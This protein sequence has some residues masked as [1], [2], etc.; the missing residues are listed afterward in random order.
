MKILIL[1]PRFPLPTYKGDKLRVWQ[2]IRKLATAHELKLI[3]YI[4]EPE[5]VHLDE[6]SQY[7]DVKTVPD[8]V[9]DRYFEL[10]RGIGN[11]VPFQVNYYNS[12]RMR[13]LVSS[14]LHDVDAIHL[15]TIRMAGNLPT[16]FHGRLVVDFIDALSLNFKRRCDNART[17]FKYVYRLEF[18]RLKRFERI[19]VERADLSLA[20]SPV[21]ADALGAKTAVLPTCVD[22][23]KFYPPDENSPRRNLI[24]TGNLSYI[25]NIEAVE[26]IALHAMPIIASKFPE[27]KL[28]LVGINPHPRVKS[29][30]SPN[31]EVVGYVNSVADELRKAMVAVAPMVSGAGLQNK[32]L[33]AMACAAPVVSTSIGNAGIR[34]ENNKE[35]LIGDTPVEF[36]EQVI[37][38]LKDEAMARAIGRAGRAFVENNF[39]WESTT[40]KLLSL[41]DEII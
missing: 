6:V 35:I 9:P 22:L 38:L 27:I 7:C 2:I 30:E 17:P 11:Q 12:G 33:E 10:F 23:K 36:A 21:D 28:R 8:N 1:T 20:V 18:E 3:S 15:S 4:S 34:A 31:I 41:Y 39:G 24:F 32:I 16:D 29:L 19:M 26:T 13:E 37:N 14:A 5:K 25:S 40:E